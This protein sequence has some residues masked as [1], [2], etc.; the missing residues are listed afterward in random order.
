M[1][2]RKLVGVIGSGLIGRDPFDRRSWSGSSHFL[3]TWLHRAGALHRAFGVEAPAWQR[4]F[5]MLKSFSGVRKTWRR[6]FYLDTRYYQSL[7]NEVKRNLVPADFEHDF[8]QLGAV[9][10]VPALVNGRS[11]CFSYHDGNLAQFVRSPDAPRGLGARRVDRALAYERKVYQGMTKILSMSEYLR[12]SFIRDFEIPEERV[13][14]IG[15]GINVE[16]VPEYVPDKRYDCRE[17]LFV[18]VDFSR[19]GGWQLLEAFKRVRQRLPDAKLHLVGPKELVIPPGLEGGVTFHGYLNKSLPADNDRLAQL[20][21]RCC[22]FVM[23]SLWEPFGIA[24]L[25]AMVH[26]LP[27]LVTNRWALREIVT[28]GLTG[29][30]VECADLDDLEVKL[31]SLLSDPHSLRIMGEAGRQTVIQRYTWPQVIKRLIEAM[32]P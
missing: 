6:R 17:V 19:K 31:C 12:D 22:L 9:F 1:T 32:S 15:A 26:Q 25:E 23:P 18:G 2:A 10:D 13:V 3:F 11:R 7:T 29:D 14:N 21:R 30:H 5:C 8:L 20:Y 27:C 24:S 4:Y 28:P 16:S